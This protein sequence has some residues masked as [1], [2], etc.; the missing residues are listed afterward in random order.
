MLLWQCGDIGYTTTH[1]C[2]EHVIVIGTAL[3]RVAVPIE[4]YTTHFASAH[5]FFRGGDE[6]TGFSWIM[7]YTE[8]GYITTHGHRTGS[9]ALSRAIC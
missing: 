3:T 9:K 1:G 8:D 2:R 4:Y 6:N 7:L 5:V